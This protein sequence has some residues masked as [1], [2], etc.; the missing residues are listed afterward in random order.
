[1]G[2]CGGSARLALAA[3]GTARAIQ[4]GADAQP[5]NAPLT[6]DDDIEGAETGSMLD[7]PTPAGQGR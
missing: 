3:R 6:R 5:D 7:Q 1:M 4:K 2:G